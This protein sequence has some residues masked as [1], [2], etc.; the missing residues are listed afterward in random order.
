MLQLGNI[1]LNCLMVTLFI[2]H[3]SVGPE[4]YKQDSEAKLLTLTIQPFIASNNAN[5]SNHHHQNPLKFTLPFIFVL[6]QSPLLYVLNVHYFLICVSHLTWSLNFVLG[7]PMNA[8][9]TSELLC[10]QESSIVIPI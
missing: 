5:L 10:S 9:L 2:A 3:I 7:I 1:V 6:Q 8:N 4:F